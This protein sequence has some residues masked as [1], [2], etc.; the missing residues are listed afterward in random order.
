M[1]S[2]SDL[3]N[4]RENVCIHDYPFLSVDVDEN[5]RHSFP[6]EILKILKANGVMGLPPAISRAILDKINPH[7]TKQY[8][9]FSFD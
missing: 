7:A 6:R 8:F 4:R 3:P 9:S 2:E 5:T 1:K